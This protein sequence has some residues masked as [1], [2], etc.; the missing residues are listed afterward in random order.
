[1]TSART[2]SVIVV[3]DDSVTDVEAA[4]IRNGLHMFAGVT[5]VL[6]VRG[7]PSDDQAR[8]IL[9]KDQLT[10]KLR[11]AEQQLEEV[12]SRLEN[13]QAAATGPVPSVYGRETA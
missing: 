13:V 11:H 1:M 8:T 2:R 10:T 5:R 9:A 12:S 6:P 4:M 3:F 7:V